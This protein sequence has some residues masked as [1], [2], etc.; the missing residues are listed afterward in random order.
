MKVFEEVAIAPT[1]LV[2]ELV[3]WLALGRPPLSWFGEEETDVREEPQSFAENFDR[4][5]IGWDGFVREEF[6]AIDA[7]V[8]F[9]EYENVRHF[10]GTPRKAPLY[11][12]GSVEDMIVYA[13]G[14]G[15]DPLEIFKEQKILN[16]EFIER[17][18]TQFDWYL[19]RAKISVLASIFDGKI[20][21]KGIIMPDVGCW[22]YDL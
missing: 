19:D 13:E 1:M 10:F 2:S 11:L 14:I 21:P 6:E 17:C 20:E 22:R 9:D 7:N 18:E 8:D 3:L 16:N 12:R 5:A 15:R 4:Y